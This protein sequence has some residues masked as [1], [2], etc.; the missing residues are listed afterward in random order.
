MAVLLYI[1]IP[2]A[3]GGGN[4]KQAALPG[5]SKLSICNFNAKSNAA[6]FIG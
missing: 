1:R 4:A 2:A 5:C 6:K 3:Q